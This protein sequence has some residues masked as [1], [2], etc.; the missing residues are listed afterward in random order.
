MG[1][2]PG[3]GGGWP[4][5]PRRPRPGFTE[6]GVGEFAGP[7]V[8]GKS[9]DRGLLAGGGA[10]RSTHPT[11]EI[12]IEHVGGGGRSTW[13]PVERFNARSRA[14]ELGRRGGAPDEDSRTPKAEVPNARANRERAQCWRLSR[15]LLRGSRDLRGPCPR[16]GKTA[17]GLG[18]TRHRNPGTRGAT[19]RPRIR[20][21]GEDP[22]GAG[23][24]IA[25]GACGGGGP[26]ARGG[27]G[28]LPSTV[29][30]P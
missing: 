18:A 25:R 27:P 22:E 9:S 11:L 7:A 13:L 6:A 12:E 1:R 28:A 17:T 23:R 5:G 8:W 16:R 15:G 3:P 26:Q 4:D 29:Q 20:A 10:Q 24:G 19:G 2:A 14:A 30:P 21:R